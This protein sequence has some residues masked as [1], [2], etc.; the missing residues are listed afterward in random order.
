MIYSAYRQGSRCGRG[1][2]GLAPPTF[3]FMSGKILRYGPKTVCQILTDSFLPAIF[4]QRVCFWLSAKLQPLPL[5]KNIE[6]PAY[7][8]GD[9]RG[10]PSPPPPDFSLSFKDR[11]YVSY[12]NSAPLHPSP[13]TLFT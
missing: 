4:F 11:K 1:W 10:V 3:H 2:G 6:S 7:R 9:E 12:V 5:L 13:P 8:G